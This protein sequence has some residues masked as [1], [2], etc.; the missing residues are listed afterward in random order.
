MSSEGAGEFFAVADHRFSF[1][2][3][4]AQISITSERRMLN[5]SAV[6]S[7]DALDRRIAR[8]SSAPRSPDS[9]RPSWPRQGAG[10]R[11]SFAAVRT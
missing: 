7:D 2:Q 1:G 5:C 8:T 4:R 9:N 10:D 6:V 3:R 11:L